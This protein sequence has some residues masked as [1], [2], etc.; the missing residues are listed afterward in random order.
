M[1]DIYATDFIRT[2]LHVGI[3]FSNLALQ[4]K[5]PDKVSRNTAHAQQ[6]YDIAQRRLRKTALSEESVTEIRSLLVQLE[7]N[8]AL[9]G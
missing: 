5:N 2:E 1:A 4:S 3:T 8:L 7:T 6:A 9:L